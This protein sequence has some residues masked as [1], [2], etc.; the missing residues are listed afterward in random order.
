[1]DINGVSLNPSESNPSS[2]PFLSLHGIHYGVVGTREGMNNLFPFHEGGGAP[3]KCRGVL[4]KMTQTDVTGVL[5]SV[6]S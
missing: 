3:E 1:M 4:P 2:R 5:R 6:D